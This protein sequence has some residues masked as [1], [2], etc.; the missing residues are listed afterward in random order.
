MLK[1]Q[2][3]MKIQATLQQE[4][5]IVAIGASAGGLEAIHE[6]FDNMPNGSGIAFV[7]IQH[8]SSDHKSLLVELVAR[9]T[10]MQVFEAKDNVE[11]NANCVYVIPNNKLISLK[12]NKL[13]LEE[14]RGDKSPN[15]AVDVFFQSLAKEKKQKAIAVVLSGTGSDG[16]KGIESVKRNGGVVMV[17]EPESA[18][19]NGMPN[20]AVHSGFVDHILPVQEMPAEIIVYSKQHWL[21]SAEKQILDEAVLPRIFDLIHQVAG[22]DFHYY[23]T[24][25]IVR[26]ILRRMAKHN[27]ATAAEYLQKLENDPEECKALGKDF[28]IGVTR[29]FRDKDAFKVLKKE[30]ITP[31]L[32][33]KQDGDTVKV[34]I[35]AC[36]TGEEAYS[37]AILLNETARELKKT[38]D[39]KLFASDLE[40]ANIAIASRGVY[41]EAAFHEMET[42][43]RDQWFQRKENTYT[44]VPQL[45]KQVVFAK[46]NIISDAPFIKNDLV[47]CRNML[48]YMNPVLQQKVLST[49]VYAVKTG[50]C[51]FL[52]P[53]ENI[54]AVKKHLAE[55][56]EKWK[57]YRKTGETTF[58]SQHLSFI[59]A[60]TPRENDRKEEKAPPSSKQP[61]LQEEVFRVL[62]EELKTVS[63]FIDD[64]FNIEET[65]GDYGQFLSMPRNTLNL[66]LL[67]MVPSEVSF[68]ISTETRKAIKEKKKVVIA[69]FHFNRNGQPISWKIVIKPISRQI[70]VTIIEQ[71]SGNEAGHIPPPLVLN[72]GFADNYALALENELSEARKTLQ[73]T[74]ESLETA[75]EELQS[76]NEELLSA[77]EELQSSNEELQSLNEELHT[78]NAEHQLKIKELIEL[79]DDL[80]NY[81]R[82]TDIGQIFLDQELKIRKFNPAA[83]QVVNLID[84][85]TGRPFTNISHNIRYD[86]LHSDL[87]DVLRNNSHVEKEILLQNGKQMLMRIMPYLRHDKKNGGII[88]SFV[89]ITA[90][91]HLNNIVKGVFNSSKSA[92]LAFRSVRDNHHLITDFQLLTANN[93]AHKML[94]SSADAKEPQLL[95]KHFP[96]LKENDLF[97]QLKKVVQEDSFWHTD[98]YSERKQQWFEITAVKMMDGFVVS[99]SDISTKKIAEQ[100][101]KLHYTEL[102][103]TKDKLKQANNELESKVAERTRALSESE[104][105]F[106]LVA[107]ATNDA[108]WD[109]NLVTNE[110]WWN[111]TFYT[112]FGFAP[113]KKYDSRQS[114]KERIHPEDAADVESGIMSAINSNQ[115]QWTQEYRFRKENGEYANI[116]DR[117]Y[118]L[119]DEQ[120]TPFRMLGSMFDITEI[121]KAEQKIAGMNEELE[122]KVKERTQ[123]LHVL[124]QAL[125]ISNNDLQQFASVASHDLQEPLRKIQMFAN[126]LQ[127]EFSN[128]LNTRFSSYLD[129][130]IISSD[131]MKALIQDILSYSRLSA[132]HDAFQLS[133]VNAIITGILDDFELSISD[134]NATVL[135]H[136]IPQVEIIP[137]QVRQ[138][139]HN[140]ISNALKFIHPSRSP[141]IE[142]SSERIENK[143]FDAPATPD[144]KFVKIVF[145][146]NGIGF[147]LHSAGNIFNLFHRL[148]SKDKFEGTGIGLAVAKKIVEKHNGLITVHSIEN[149]GTTFTI[150]LP[151]KQQQID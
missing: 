17:Q 41:P 74:V 1:T 11:L 99:I 100:K 32:E 140:L 138:V 49:L 142:I 90:I 94:N 18:K 57:I 65:L 151:C 64:Q 115:P 72:E 105:R 146:D 62:N 88:L 96:L 125:E 150:V 126:M 45:R 30:F 102:I 137:G 51:I 25:T 66:N 79:N 19:F 133:D 20:S 8:L 31:L 23:K 109:W 144:G 29:F 33:D 76:S 101:L 130:I 59:A 139:F 116:L 134:K 71:E 112:K 84:G 40:E 136:P 77:N 107:R 61:L 111:E 106:R 3:D 43:M 98:I 14:K 78:L 5:Y 141:I 9:H 2:A 15:N 110:N 42:S 13:K 135:A 108:L 68:L 58:N 86:Q 131:R 52:G 145:K 53:S 149:E 121:K 34:W 83:L 147:D 148:H 63:F 117:G 67:R 60:Q 24:P 80:D 70:L 56:S 55:I 4:Q 75:N 143:S 89:D 27:I 92:I 85:D 113:S 127:D 35:S 48:I 132:G 93:S 37:I 104:E 128:K 97:P 129:K 7:I 69:P 123:D 46:H 21:N 6:F 39:I 28:L 120:G 10:H 12:G 50:G 47:C 95:S 36:S 124:N 103:A 119:H 81:F 91:T 87:E 16:T 118:I 22:N 54:G 82:S 44:V 114:W 26:R 122:R 38:L 73:E